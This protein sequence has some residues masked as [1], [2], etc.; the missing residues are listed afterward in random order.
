MFGVTS[1]L[2]NISWVD[3]NMS[4]PRSI[5]V[6]ARAMVSA[7]V[8]A[9]CFIGGTVLLLDDNMLLDEDNK[10]LDEDNKFLDEDNKLL[11]E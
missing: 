1:F 9:S 11:D 10:F 5:K 2:R 4:D 3:E 8:A 7:V 6:F